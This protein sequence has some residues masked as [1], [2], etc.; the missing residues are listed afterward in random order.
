MG[1]RVG[2]LATAAGVSVD[3][4]RSYQSKGLLPPP[5]HRGRIALYGERHLERLRVIRDLKARGYSLRAIASVLDADG[6]R[7]REGPDPLAQLTPASRELLTLGQIAQRSGVPPGMLRSLEASGVIRS[8]PGA[9]GARYSEEDVAAIHMLLE[10]IGTGLP[11]EE[12]LALARGLIQPMEVA[13]AEAVSAFRR[14]GL[15]IGRSEGARLDARSAPEE[16]ALER[17]VHAATYLLAYHFERMLRLAAAG[18]GAAR[19]APTKKRP[20]R[21]EGSEALPA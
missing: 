7:E 15:E 16:A 3:L 19:P 4:I 5:R 6:A 12:F 18:A 9:G 21:Q 11:L 14:Y 17:M 1:Y 13:A 2:E 10:L 20:A 8:L